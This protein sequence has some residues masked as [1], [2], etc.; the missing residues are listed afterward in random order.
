MN[1]RKKKPQT[2]VR[3]QGTREVFLVRYEG[4]TRVILYHDMSQQELQRHLKEGWEVYR[5]WTNA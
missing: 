5:A 4:D 3:Y 2:F 1:R